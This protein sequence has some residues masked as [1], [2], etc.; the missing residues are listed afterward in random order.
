MRG[1][2]L[3]AVR[4]L[5]YHRLRTVILVACVALTLYLPVAARLLLSDFERQLM[6]RAEATPLVV[7]ARGSRFDLALHAL[8]FD[9]EPPAVITMS[10]ADRIAATGWA[11]PIPLLIRYRARGFPIAGTTLEYFAFRKLHVAE[12]TTFLRLGDCVLGAGAARRL[13]LRPGDRILS[14][15][16]NVFDIAGAY[17]LK[18]RVAGV[19][20]EAHSPDDLAVFVDV[21]TAWI[22]DGLGHGHQQLD[23]VR[24]EGVVLERTEAQV[25]AGAALR[26]YTEITDANIDSFHFHGEREDFPLTAVIAVPRDEKSAT[27]LMGRFLAP[28]EPTQ[29]LRPREV[30]DELLAL[31]FRI[32]RFFDLSAWLLGVVTLLFLVLVLLLSLRLR[33]REMQTMF[34]LGCSR[35]TIF[36]L[37]VTELGLVLAL[38]TT[39]AAG[40]A[41]ATREFAPSLLQAWLLG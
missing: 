2:L 27:L 26:Q 14:D 41:I 11:T 29:I 36:R 21:K 34:K 39:V 18:M 3:L 17:P 25:V 10:S 20:E 6:A 22:I 24:D 5:A 13:G 23:Q 16:L 1:V 7:G 9:A 12:G 8:Y 33:Q 19:L 37:Q 40:L 38:A 32:K 35:F 30:V 31:V 28:N 15:P 4:F